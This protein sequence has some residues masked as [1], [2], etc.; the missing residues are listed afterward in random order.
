MHCLL[1]FYHSKSLFREADIG[2][3]LSDCARPGN[4][5]PEKQS[6]LL[7]ADSLRSPMGGNVAA[8]SSR[9][10]LDSVKNTLGGEIITWQELVK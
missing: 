7:K 10:S 2:I 9:A 6:L 3:W 1:S 4:L 8:F 5:I